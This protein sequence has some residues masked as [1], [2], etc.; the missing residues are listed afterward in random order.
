ME[1]VSEKKLKRFHEILNMDCAMVKENL[2]LRKLFS[3]GK[4]KYVVLCFALL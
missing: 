4:I 2:R 1:N 3:V